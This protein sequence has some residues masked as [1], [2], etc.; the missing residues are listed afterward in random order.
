MCKCTSSNTNTIKFYMQAIYNLQFKMA[1]GSNLWHMKTFDHVTESMKWRFYERLGWNQKFKLNF[2]CN[3]FLTVVSSLGDKY[4]FYHW[5]CIETRN[6]KIF[7]LQFLFTCTWDLC[8]WPFQW[9]KNNALGSLLTPWTKDV[10]Y[11]D[12]ETSSALCT[13]NAVRLYLTRILQNL[14]LARW[15]F[16]GS[17]LGH[18]EVMWPAQGCFLT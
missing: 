10:L 4:Q 1:E 2:K 18:V 14:N 9:G 5:L 13:K 7:K 8:P 12:L 6:T 16:L 17:H 15:P 11:H 3:A